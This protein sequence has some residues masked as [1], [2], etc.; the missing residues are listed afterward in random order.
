MQFRKEK[1]FYDLPKNEMILMTFYSH[2]IVITI[3]RHK[4]GKK[5]GKKTGR[6]LKEPYW[7]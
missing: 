3:L 5:E 6:G 4:D 2:F 7:K 1:R